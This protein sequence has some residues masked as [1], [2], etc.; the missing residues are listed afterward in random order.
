MSNISTKNKSVF[1]E[2]IG[3]RFTDF[4]K[5]M[6]RLSKQCNIIFDEDIF[7]STIIYCTNTFFNSNATNDDIDKYFW[8]SY[9][10]NVLQY[11]LR[12]KLIY[13]EDI[14]TDFDYIEDTSYNCDKYKIVEIIKGEIEKDFGKSILDAWILHICEGLTYEELEERGYNQK[15]LHNEFRQIKRHILNKYVKENK[16]LHDLLIDN[17]FIK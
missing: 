13:K 9:K 16:V 8:Q 15:L 2:N 12:N 6:K 5:R 10:N 4:K 7:M 14:E 1:F 3:S 17:D 11:C